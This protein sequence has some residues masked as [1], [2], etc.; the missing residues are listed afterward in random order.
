MSYFAQEPDLILLSLSFSNLEDG[1]GGCGRWGW[2]RGKKRGGI[3]KVG[4]QESR[5]RQEAAALAVKAGLNAST[6]AV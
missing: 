3:P 6:I 5:A 2:R 1:V 4:S